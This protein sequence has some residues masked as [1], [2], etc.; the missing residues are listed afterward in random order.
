M[1]SDETRTTGDKRPTHQTCDDCESLRFDG[2]GRRICNVHGEQLC[3]HQRCE[4]FQPADG[5][6]GSV[7]L[8]ALVALVVGAMGVATA[9]LGLSI[10]FGR[11]LI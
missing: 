1:K 3:N 7:L 2:R 4:Q 5:R 11:A 10:V 6:R 8:G 9:L